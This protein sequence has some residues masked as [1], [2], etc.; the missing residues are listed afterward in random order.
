MRPFES[1][2]GVVVETDPHH[3]NQVPS[4]ACEPTVVVGARLTRCIGYAVGQSGPDARAI[5]DHILHDVGHHVGHSGVHDLLRL[6]LALVQRLASIVPHVAH[7]AGLDPDAAIG[8]RRVGCR[9]F[10]R[11]NLVSAEK[12]GRYRQDFRSHA[13]A[14]GKVEYALVTSHLPDFYR[15]DVD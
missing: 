14:V 6:H 4:E 8:K 13:G 12:H 11:S 3:T 10:N 7:E 15:R 9:D 1:K 5:P 2:V